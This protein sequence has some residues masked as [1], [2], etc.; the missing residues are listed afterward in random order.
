VVQCGCAFVS[1]TARSDA[2]EC[3]QR[4]RAMAVMPRRYRFTVDE[5][6]R[7][8]AAGVLTRCDRVERSRT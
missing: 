3:R 4:R 7:L 6:D 5:Y 2:T 8:A 1:V